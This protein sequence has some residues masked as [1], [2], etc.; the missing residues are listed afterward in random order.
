[1]LIYICRRAEHEPS[2]KRE[3]GRLPSE[4]C[5]RVEATSD[6]NPPLA[7][8]LLTL[9]VSLASMAINMRSGEVTR[10]PLEAK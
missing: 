2:R 6:V 5:H 8:V 9:A 4:S 10:S 1:M 7:I 3:V